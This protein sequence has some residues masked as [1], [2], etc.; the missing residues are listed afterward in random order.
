M[1]CEFCFE[2]SCS[3]D[4]NQ[5]LNSNTVR[6][7][8]EQWKMALFCFH[9]LYSQTKERMGYTW[10]ERS[11]V[12]MQPSIQCLDQQC[13]TKPRQTNGCMHNSCKESSADQGVSK[14]VPRHS[15][16]AVS[17]FGRTHPPPPVLPFLLIQNLLYNS[18]PYKLKNFIFSCTDWLEYIN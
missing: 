16:I 18:Y 14:A 2:L 5:I 6:H 3:W 4:H 1:C 10:M 8:E 12:L 13:S 7:L 17:S 11:Q 9:V 15:Y